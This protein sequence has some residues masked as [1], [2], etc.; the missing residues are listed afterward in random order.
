MR[1]TVVWHPSAERELAEIWLRAVDRAAVSDAANTIDRLLTSD[2]LAHGEEFYGERL[3]VV[4]PLAVTYTVSEH[5]RI[6][7]I[8]QVW[9][10]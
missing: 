8:L 5:D 2:P 7:Q 1:F 4:L 6:V 10:Q 3:F 9:H